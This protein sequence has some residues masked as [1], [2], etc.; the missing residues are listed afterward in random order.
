MLLLNK[1]IGNKLQLVLG[2]DYFNFLSHSKNYISAGL[3]TQGL[4]FITIPIFTRLLLPKDYGVLAILTSFIAIFGILY[5][6]SIQ[7]SVVRYYYESLN[8]FDK[9]LGSTLALIIGWCILFT[10]ILLIF[11]QQLQ[12]FFQI[13]LPIIYIGISIVFCQVFFTLYQSY[14]QASKQSK[15]VALLTIIQKKMIF[16]SKKF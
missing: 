9:F 8:D 5:G 15:R 2:K 12:T 4:S 10:I 7:G 11:S 6:L 16:S 1:K 14:L 3:F 13:P